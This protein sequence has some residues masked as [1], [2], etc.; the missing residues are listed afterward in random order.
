[1]N[2]ITTERHYKITFQD[3]STYYGR[4]TQLGNKRYNV[5]LC[6]A[7]K[8]KHSNKHIQEIY[9]K[10]GSDN[11][12]HEWL[13]EEIGDL[14]YHNKIELGYVQSDPKAINIRDGSCILDRKKYGR[15]QNQALR[16]A[17]SLEKREESNR[18]QRVRD[19]NKQKR[20]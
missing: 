16:N 3:G 6:H 20:L 2:K 14:E 17:W 18:K 10:Y 9:N 13:G 12:V 8:G 4:T 1:M 11:W 7:K 15:E 5:H 19:Q